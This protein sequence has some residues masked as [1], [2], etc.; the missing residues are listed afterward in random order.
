M[1]EVTLEG[2]LSKDPE[3]RYI[4]AS[5]AAVLNFD[6][7]ENHKKKQG[8]EYVN[9]GTTWYR[10]AVFARG[11]DEPNNAP[12]EALASSLHKGAR[13]VV[14]GDLRMT[15]REHN[16]Q[17]YKNLE[18]TARSVGIVP[19]AP[20]NNGGQA[21]QQGWSQPQQAAPQGDPW[22]APQG[23]GGWAAGPSTNEPPF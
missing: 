5:G 19:Q 13:V 17:V 4:P 8:N 15:E 12:V 9:D 23:G 2:W 18:V 16:G 1:A 20:S 10:V 22:A 7:P 14:R 3:M 6:L 21:S 11:R